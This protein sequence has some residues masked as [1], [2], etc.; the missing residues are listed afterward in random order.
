MTDEEFE[1]FLKGLNAKQLESFI[2]RLISET[3]DLVEEAA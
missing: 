2:D 3:T 1:R